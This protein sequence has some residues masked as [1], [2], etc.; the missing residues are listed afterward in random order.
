[1]SNSNPQVML[2]ASAMLC[3]LAREGKTAG[4]IYAVMMAEGMSLETF[5]RIKGMLI[6]VDALREKE[7]GVLIC[8]KQGDNIISAALR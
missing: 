3:E 6:V 7:N 4:E 5:E 1:M 2:L 8:T